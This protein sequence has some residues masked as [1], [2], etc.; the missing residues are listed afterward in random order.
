MCGYS[1]RHNGNATMPKTTIRTVIPDDLKASIQTPETLIEK[2]VETFSPTETTLQIFVDAR[3][4]AVFCECHVLAEKIV[5][6]STKDVPLDPEEQPEYRANREIVADHSAF[7]AMKED[8]KQ[9]R[10][11]SN[12]VTEFTTEFDPDFPLKIIGGQHR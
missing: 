7:I 9:R 2:F 10:S 5:A 11:F 1:K 12:I 6:L 3:T 8:A 4:N